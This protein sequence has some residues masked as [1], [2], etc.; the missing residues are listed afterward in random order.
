MAHSLPR[1]I[2]EASQIL[3]SGISRIWAGISAEKKKLNHN[4][5]TIKRFEQAA[6]LVEQA[7]EL[8]T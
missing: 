1:Q 2:Y 3:D 6:Q 5:D 8:L 7:K 4:P